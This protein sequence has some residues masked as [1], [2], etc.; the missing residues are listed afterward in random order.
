MNLSFITSNT[1]L[2]ALNIEKQTDD[3]TLGP[4]SVYV[5]VCVY[6]E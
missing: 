3:Q 1:N 4:G 6:P 5:C 2:I